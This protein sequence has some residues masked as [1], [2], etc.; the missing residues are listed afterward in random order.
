MYLIYLY[1][2]ADARED[3]N[4]STNTDLASWEALNKTSSA[5]ALVRT[6]GVEP[7]QVVPG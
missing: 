7:Q 4:R 3:T 2:V 6:L 1:F 5:Q